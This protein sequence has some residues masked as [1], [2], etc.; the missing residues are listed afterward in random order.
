MRSFFVDARTR[1]VEGFFLNPIDA[2]RNM[3]PAESGLFVSVLAC[4]A[5][6]EFLAMV[7]N[8]S[9]QENLIASW[10][11]QSFAGRSALSPLLDSL[12]SDTATIS[13]IRH[14]SASDALVTSTA[15]SKSTVPLSR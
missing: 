4:A 13:P 7:E 11:D 6:I 9:Q 12:R 2:L 10:L 14:I 3:E 1:R 5:T 8:P 15:S